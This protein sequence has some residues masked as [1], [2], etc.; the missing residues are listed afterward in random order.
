MEPV[1]VSRR[2]MA[3]QFLVGGSSRD[4]FARMQA[5]SLYQ[6][7]LAVD[8]SSTA[9][10]WVRRG[11][12]PLAAAMVYRNVGKT[13]MLLACPAA[14][15]GVDVEQLVRLV[16]AL[17]REEIHGGLS[18]IQTLLP[19]EAKPEL[20]MLDRAG[21]HRLAQLVYLHLAVPLARGTPD[22]GEPALR[23]LGEAG[24][25]APRFHVASEF[26]PRELEDV[27]RRSYEQSRDCPGL[28]GVRDVAD[29]VT[30]HRASGL[31][32]PESWWIVRVQDQSAGCL[33]LNESF[34]GETGDIVYL[35]VTPEFRRRGLGRVM[36]Q[37]AISHA[38]RV[39]WRRLSLAADA[40]NS[41][42]V[43]LYESFH[44]SVSHRRDAWIYT[45]KD[46]TAGFSP[47]N[48]C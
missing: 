23:S 2:R 8:S 43:V 36:I 31:F 34:S 44:F 12:S 27:I 48:G 13:G 17:S 5:E 30:G 37:R 47:E 42:A 33:L 6:R 40:T 10:W 41:P 45:W 4:S 20:I 14:A 32:S 19:T 3:L 38:Q 46:A 18:M 25:P 11:R 39:G 29:V 15:E 1:P 28:E 22:T 16:R 35:G 21:Y 26:P 7:T 24:T 9:L